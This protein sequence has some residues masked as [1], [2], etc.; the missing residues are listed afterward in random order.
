MVDL[1]TV[2]AGTAATTVSREVIQWLR[3]NQEGVS[4]SEWAEIGVMVGRE[5]K[6]TH[7]QDFEKANIPDRDKVKRV[8]DRSGKIF[9]ELAFVGDERGFD[10]TI[11]EHYSEL[12][13]ICAQWSSTPNFSSGEAYVKG[14]GA[15][16][17]RYGEYKDAVQ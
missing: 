1:L 13:D 12:A 7:T 14:S 8:A 16:L 3:S 11:V 17:E 6:S 5:L 4:E 9:R 2:L 15:F 10:S